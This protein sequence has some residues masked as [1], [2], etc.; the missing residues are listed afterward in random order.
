[1][2]LIQEIHN[3]KPAVRYALFGL[4]VVTVLA[5]VGFFGVTAIQREMFMALHT[6]PQERSDF[7]AQQ[8]ARSPKPLAA[9]VRVASSLTASIG[10]LLGFNRNAGFD[11]SVR[12]GDTSGDVHP[13]PL[14]Q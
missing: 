9:L 1:M 2:S 7:L 6:D 12:E 8:D 14:S 11:K 3:Q 10:S 13:L 4:A 5:V